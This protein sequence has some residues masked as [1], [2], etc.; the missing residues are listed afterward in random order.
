MRTFRLSYDLKARQAAGAVHIGGDRPLPGSA[1]PSLAATSVFAAPLFA[2][3][4][5]VPA[6]Q[7][8]LTIT[9]LCHDPH[10][11]PTNPHNCPEYGLSARSW[12]DAPAE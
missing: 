1:Q 11:T 8:Q 3:N 5:E 6:Q 7:I 4:G 2:S 9:Q 12:S 10:F